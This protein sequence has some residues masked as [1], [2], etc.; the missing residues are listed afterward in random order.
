MDG[1]TLV[2]KK[3]S[4]KRQ[5]NRYK[6]NLL[7]SQ[8]RLLSEEIEDEKCI[9]EK[10]IEIVSKSIESSRNEIQLS[11]FWSDIRGL[12]YSTSNDQHDREIQTP[13]H[14]HEIISYGIGNFSTNP[15]ARY[16]FALLILLAG[17]L[18]VEDKVHLYDPVLS[19]TE[20]CIIENYGFHLI[21]QN[22][23]CKRSVTRKTLIFMLHCGKKM[24]DNL[25][26]ANWNAGICNL[27]IIG[28][29]FSSYHERI[30]S[31]TLQKEAP[32]IFHIAP[33]SCEQQIPNSFEHEDIFNDS[34]LIKF[35]CELVSKLEEE[36]WLKERTVVDA[37][38]DVEIIRNK[39][40][41]GFLTDVANKERE[42]TDS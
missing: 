9:T 22:E 27:V 8:N 41:K 14:F 6:M 23:E 33:H 34:C 31:T 36:F 7:D 35:P 16:Q 3:S 1:F 18:R 5:K 39:N 17:F 32:H 40:V 19:M 20:R 38:D 15:I 11:K 26:S 28:N 29:A 24:Y 25:L 42:I 37:E 10:Q 21:R 2:S 12:F 30:P 13:E 4:R